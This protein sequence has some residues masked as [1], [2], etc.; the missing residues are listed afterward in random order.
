MKSFLLFIML[1]L[2]P[3]HADNVRWH[4]N[5]DK[6][7]QK[8]LREKK[9]L[10]VLLVEKECILCNEILKTTFQN[11]PYIKWINKSFVPVLII[12]GQKQSYPI[13]M[14]YTMTYPSVFFLDSEELFI[15]ENIFGYIDPKAFQKHLNLY[16]KE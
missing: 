5:Y 2:I 11:Q 6:A 9:L 8:A 12:S 3:L 15:G 1:F 16:I 13:E 14:L 10:M 4:S 7:H